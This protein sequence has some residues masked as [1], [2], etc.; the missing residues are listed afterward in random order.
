MCQPL[1]EPN[2][3]NSPFMFHQHEFHLHDSVGHLRSPELERATSKPIRFKLKRSDSEEQLLQGE[4]DAEYRDFLMYQ[5]ITT[6]ML[7]K[8]GKSDGAVFDPTLDSVIRTRH[9]ITTAV[10]SSNSIKHDS[11]DLILQ[12]IDSSTPPLSDFQYDPMDSSVLSPLT[13]NVGRAPS[14]SRSSPSQRRLT[15]TCSI[16]NHSNSSR[17]TYTD[18]SMDDDRDEN[19]DIFEMEL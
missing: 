1:D 11:Q 17:A 3:E 8:M 15:T 13:T 7:S 19:D 9:A 18:N 5:R 12:D 4:M 14:T 2:K 10:P 16:R 6:G